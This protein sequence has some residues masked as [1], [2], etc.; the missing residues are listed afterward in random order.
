MIRAILIA[1][2]LLLIVSFYAQNRD[3]E[4][5]VR[6]LFGVQETST[7]LFVPILSAFVIGLLVASAFLL[8]PWLRGRM[9]LRRKSKALQ[10]VEADVERLRRSMEQ[11]FPKAKGVDVRE[12]IE[13]FVDE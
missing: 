3:Q 4:V 7:V 9:E 6:Y 1:I 8:P 10:E 12:G 13:E 2:L 11:T 5:T